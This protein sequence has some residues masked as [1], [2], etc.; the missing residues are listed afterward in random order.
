MRVCLLY[1]VVFT[2]Y[3]FLI[4]HLFSYWTL[5]FTDEFVLAGKI[6]APDGSEGL[7]WMRDR[8]QLIENIEVGK[9]IFVYNTIYASI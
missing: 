5:I 4:Y 7:S 2:L 6:H 9:Y 8:N 3:L 1:Y